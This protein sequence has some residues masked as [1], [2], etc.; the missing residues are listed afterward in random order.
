M[1]LGTILKQNRKKSN[2]KLKDVAEEVGKTVRFIIYIEKGERNPSYKL[3]CK[4]CQLY[5]MDK[6]PI[7]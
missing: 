3:L 1:T 2:L 6:L 7:A 5:K 4:L